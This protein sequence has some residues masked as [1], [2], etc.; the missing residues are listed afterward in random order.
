M[1]FITCVK[2]EGMIVVVQKVEELQKDITKILSHHLLTNIT[3]FHIKDN[4]KIQKYLF[5]QYM[6]FFHMNM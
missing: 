6:H 4:V 3:L 1:C 2:V 5:K